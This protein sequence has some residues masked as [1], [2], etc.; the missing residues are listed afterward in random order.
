MNKCCTVV[1]YYNP[2]C[3][4]SRHTLALI[5]SCGIEPRVIDC[6]K[7][8]PSSYLLQELIASAELGVR[9]FLRKTALPYLQYYLASPRWSDLQ[10]IELMS[11]HPVL[12]KA[13]IV[14]SDFGTRLCRSAEQV[15]D[16]L[17]RPQ[18]RQLQQ[19]AS[20]SAN[21]ALYALREVG[22]GLTAD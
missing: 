14:V 20:S 9:D 7:H 3:S 2:A 5:R 22:L 1:I 11:R 16:I 6:L 18:L 17:P 15:L 21:Q 8:P 13:P 4:L 10:L 19:Y 12:I